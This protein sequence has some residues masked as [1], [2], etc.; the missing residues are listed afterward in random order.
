MIV[1]RDPWRTVETARELA[2]LRRAAAAADAAGV[3]VRLG[4]LEQAAVD[5]L[6][7]REDGWTAVDEAFR[8]AARRVA[9]AFLA[10]ERGVPSPAPL[11][12]ALAALDAH[13][14]RLPP[15]LVVRPPEGYAHYALDP[16]GYVRAAERYRA[17]VGAARAARAVVIGVRSIGTSLSAVVAA[18]VGAG[19]TATVRPRGE[20]GARRVAADAAL[21]RRLV[22]WLRAGGDALIV[23]EG[24]GATGETFA[25]VAAW[26]RELGVEDRRIVLFP[27]RDWGMPLAPPERA[28]WFGAARKFAP[29]I[30]DDRPTHVA[31]RLGLAAPRSLCGGRWRDVVPG[32]ARLPAC[33]GHERAKHLA[34]ARDGSAALLRFAGLGRWG[35]EAAD[36]ARRLAAADAGPEVLGFHD[37]FLALR[38][39]EGAPVTRDAG[40]DPAFRAALTRYLAV[41]AK[42]FVTGREVDAAPIL[43][44]LRTNA[45]EA[46][47]PA[48][49][50]LGPALR[51]LERLPAREAVVADARVHAWEWV[52]TAAGFAKVDAVD[53][54]DGLRLP[55][56]TD[57]AWDLAGAVV[58]FDLDE[59]AA[60]ELVRRCA[61][62]APAEAAALAAAV[63][64]YRP[65]YAALQLGAAMLAMHEA[66][67]AEDRARWQVEAG[68]YRAALAD[69]LLRAEA[70]ARDRRRA[71]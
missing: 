38:W 42:A 64:A 58:E 55:G 25:A 13:A 22:D 4:E 71:A 35:A 70:G 37:G 26:L 59:P 63:A 69:A 43:E 47:G 51:R 21:S 57:R 52:R 15:R 9:A 68:R 30:G 28:A 7:P 2:A 67:D 23:D 36:R 33:T 12:A 5:A 62:T 44:M 17:A 49:P 53:H 65:A 18:V 1:Y 20:T 54:G 14:G 16:R 31:A 61:G 24:P 10:A 32:A 3:L 41:R 60:A 39:A 66:E 8:R 19:R 48:T 34:A 11:R 45:A 56:P 6:H 50:G 40:R 27:S 29:P 46:L